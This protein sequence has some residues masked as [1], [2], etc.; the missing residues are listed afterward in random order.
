MLRKSVSMVV[1]ALAC[2]SIGIAIG[3]FLPWERPLYGQNP[4]P[5]DPVCEGNAVCDRD[6]T[7]AVRAC[8][9]GCRTEDKKCTDC[10]CDIGSRDECVCEL[11]Q[12]ATVP[13]S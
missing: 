4:N 3:S 5:R 1:E 12:G 6:C 13:G 2:V 11:P 7:L 9:G 10:V 8:R